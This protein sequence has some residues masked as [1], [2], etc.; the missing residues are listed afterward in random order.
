MPANTWLSSLP[1]GRET[2]FLQAL[3]FEFSPR[4]VGALFE[5]IRL[6]HETGQ[7]PLIGDPFCGNFSF[8]LAVSELRLACRV[9]VFK[10][11]LDLFRYLVVFDGVRS[12]EIVWNLTVKT[13][14]S[15]KSVN[16]F[17]DCGS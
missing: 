7:E 4:V 14:T 16:C 11:F 10:K 1:S 8:S 2:M 12:L 5:L 15:K 9:I 17:N 6:H 13:D 3:Q